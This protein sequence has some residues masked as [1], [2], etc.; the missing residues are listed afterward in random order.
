MTTIIVNQYCKIVKQLVNYYEK[1]S[2]HIDRIKHARQAR[3]VI[4]EAPV[5]VIE[6]TGPELYNRKEHILANDMQSIISTRNDLDASNTD[7]DTIDII[8]AIL[9][10]WHSSDDKNK[11]EIASAIKMLLNLYM[12]YL[13]NHA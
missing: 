5:H 12:K 7:S 1:H 10:V 2:D 9:N 3:L 8:D 13:L 6:S 4:N 11:D